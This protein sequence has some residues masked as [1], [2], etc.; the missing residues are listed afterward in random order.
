MVHDSLHFI[1]YYD[2]SRGAIKLSRQCPDKIKVMNEKRGRK[3]VKS[4]FQII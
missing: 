1:I 3:N 2:E 4:F